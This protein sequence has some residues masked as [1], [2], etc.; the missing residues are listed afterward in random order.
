MSRRQLFHQA[1]RGTAAI[2]AS[3]LIVSVP[4]PSMAA[5]STPSP[6]ELKKLQLGHSRVQVSLSWA[7]HSGS[8]YRSVVF[9]LPLMIFICLWH[10]VRDDVSESGG[11]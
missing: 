3:S 11:V 2:A 1:V 10:W 8:G 9:L 5:S 4:T 6:A 7:V